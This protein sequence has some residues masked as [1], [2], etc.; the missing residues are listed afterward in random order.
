M[1]RRCFF[2]IFFLPVIWPRSFAISSTATR[3]QSGDAVQSDRWRSAALNCLGPIASS[4]STRFRNGSLWPKK[5]G[6]EAIDY[7]STDVYDRI[8]EL[9][10][11]RGADA[12]IDAEGTEPDTQSGA[13]AVID[14]IKFATFMGTDR[15][16]VRR[17]AIQCCRNFGTVSIVGVYGGALDNLP[18]GS[19][20]NRGLT[21]KMAQT[22]VQR[23]LPMLL[24]RIEAGEIDPSFV[25]T[26]RGKLADG[27]ELYKTFRDRKDGCVKVVL[28]PSQ[29]GRQPIAIGAHVERE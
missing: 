22:P 19:A 1:N 24:A 6:A 5:V 15:P 28:Q 11:G 13:D 7:K 14:R 18:M 25:I 2:Q 23:Y 17:Q 3:S 27:P 12:C 10:K 26:H 9:T 21:F 20:I 8:Q 16:H 4:P 29:V